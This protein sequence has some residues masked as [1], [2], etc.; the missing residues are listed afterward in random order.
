MRTLIFIF[1]IIIFASGCSLKRVATNEIANAL[2]S[3]GTT[4]SADDDPDLVA[5]AMPFTLKLVE[6]IL[7]EMPDHARLRTAA[8]AYFTQYAYGFIQLEADYIEAE[9]F[10][11]AS[12]MRARAKRLFLRA[13]EHGLKRI[14]QSHFGFRVKLETNPKE[15]VRIL[16]KDLTETIYWTAAAWGSAIV[17]GKDDPF[18]VGELPQMEALI[19]H[20]LALNSEWGGGAIHNFLIAYE[21]NRK[22]DGE[23]SMQDSIHNS[24]KNSM[25]DSMKDSMH[26]PVKRARRHFD[27]AV[28]ISNGK[29]LSP[30]VSFAESVCVQIQDIDEFQMLLQKAL[31]IDLDAY[32]DAR[33]ANTL[34]R[35]RALW[36]LSQKEELFLMDENDE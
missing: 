33:L 26:D 11:K 6:S 4:F 22:S 13:R 27:E 29:M 36:L 23:D 32:P 1:V 17:L 19:D 16:K 31:D 14:E 25:K 8:A 18:L 30:F 21:M 5:D 9:N 2:A 20:A 7:A 3:S 12:S 35:K 34:M 10:E 28:I 24:M 15:A